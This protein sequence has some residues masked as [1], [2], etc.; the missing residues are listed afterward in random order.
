MVSVDGFF[1]TIKA[2]MGIPTGTSWRKGYNGASSSTTTN[3]GASEQDL[4]QNPYAEA[5][6]DITA[7]D[8]C[9]GET[10]VSY[11]YE[12]PEGE[13]ELPEAHQAVLDSFKDELNS[14]VRWVSKDLQLVG[15]SV[16][17][18]TFDED[19]GKICLLPNLKELKFYL[20]KTKQVV[21]YD[22]SEVHKEKRNLEDVIIFINYEKNSLLE[23]P[24]DNKDLTDDIVF[25]ITPTPMQFKNAKSTLDALNLIENA[26]KRYRAQLSRIVRYATVDVGLSNGDTQKDVVETISAA[27]NADSMNLT[28][29]NNEEYNDN[30]PIIPTRNS[31]GE[32]QM[33]LDVPQGDIKELPDLKYYL[34]KLN[35]IT[36]FP[37]TYMDFSQAMGSTA[38]SMIRSDLRY[39]KLCNSI[40]TLIEK[41]INEFISRT[42]SLEKYNVVFSLIQLPTSEDDDV[43]QA[44][45]NYTEV[46]SDIEGLVMGDD[47]EEP[48]EQKIHRLKSLL[49]LVNASIK[50]PVIQDWYND[51]LDYLE[52]L[53]Q[54]QN[55]GEELNG[56]AGVEGGGSGGGLGGG[57]D[58]GG[59]GLPD[60]GEPDFTSEDLG[61]GEE[62][63]GGGGAPE[64]ETFEPQT[65]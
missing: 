61:G 15:V 16:F 50:S 48:I 42:Q 37:A 12:L 5:I 26:L 28:S 57:E 45:S 64:I 49:G 59:G 7:D 31:K 24:E 13:T 25:E 55:N 23:V 46:V 60:L 34:D 10:P 41:T 53:R 1:S 36:R 21:A 38:A 20:T 56:E 6:C 19:N 8:V 30:I 3:G 47:P 65:E 4:S 43:L 18:A 44:M 22:M 51:F 14:V 54:A 33:H 27:I 62:L 35:L 32:P 40:R 11:N 17:N 9:R 39:A 29:V 63:G 58:L 2:A 52:E